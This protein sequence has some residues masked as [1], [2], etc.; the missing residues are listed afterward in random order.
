VLRVAD[1]LRASADEALVRFPAEDDGEPE[2][3]AGGAP[4]EPLTPPPDA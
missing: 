2:A 3:A 4:T 1:E